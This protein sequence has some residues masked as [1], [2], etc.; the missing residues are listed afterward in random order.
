MSDYVGRFMSGDLLQAG[1]DTTAVVVES[2]IL[3]EGSLLTGKSLQMVD[4][5]NSGCMLIGIERGDESFMNPSPEMIMH[6]GDV[7]W[8]VGEADAIKLYK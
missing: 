8:L 2:V 1:G 5:R 7:V 3:Q 4:M 6:E